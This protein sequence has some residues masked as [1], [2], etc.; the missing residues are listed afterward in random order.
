MAFLTDLDLPAAQRLGRC[1]DLDIVSCSPL[2]AGSVNSNF[3]LR[4]SD[5]DRYFARVYE[6]QGA[7]G[8]ERELRLL[9]ELAAVGVPTTPPPRRTDGGFVSEHLGK[10]VALYP[11]VDGDLLCTEAALPTRCRAVGRALARV[12]LATAELSEVAPG[13]FD[14]VQLEERLDFIMAKGR[15]EHVGAA[16]RVRELLRT[17]LP[18]RDPSLPQGLTHGDLFRD[19]V[20]WDREAPEE[21]PRIAALIDFE[22]ACRGAFA[23]DLMVTVL[24]WCFRSDFDLERVR[25]LLEGYQEVRPLTADE[26]ENLAIEGIVGCLRFATTRITDFSMRAAPGKPPLRDYNRF[27]QRL[28]ALAGGCLDAL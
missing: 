6:E 14:P 28:D 21:A 3:E 13:R 18:R 19:N 1:Y 10:P 2:A 22:S 7:E 12:H 17:W 5:R 15:A 23:Y 4:T 25:A 11:W 20:I 26:R 9:G 16:H 24:A 8:A 27:L